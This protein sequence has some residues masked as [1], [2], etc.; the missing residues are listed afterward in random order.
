MANMK[1]GRSGGWAAQ[2]SVSINPSYWWTTCTYIS[3]L[4]EVRGPRQ[5]LNFCDCGAVKRCIKHTFFF[6]VLS[7]NYECV[8]RCDHTELFQSIGIGVSHHS[9]G[10]LPAYIAAYTFFPP[11]PFSFSKNSVYTRYQ[12]Q[13]SLQS[14]LLLTSL[15]LPRYTTR[16]TWTTK[17]PTSPPFPP[18]LLWLSP[19]S[20]LQCLQA[21]T[22]ALT[23]QPHFAVPF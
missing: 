17:L 3:E 1:H 12:F 8:L 23:D 5:R 4:Y 15:S 16:R 18:P 14:S 13:N 10:N 6:P 7:L 22:R 20:L 11:P 9:A 19:N 2:L 21:C